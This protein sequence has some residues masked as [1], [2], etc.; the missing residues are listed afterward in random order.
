M[1]KKSAPTPIM[2]ELPTEALFHA[3]LVNGY[4]HNKADFGRLLSI[5]MGN[6]YNYLPSKGG[7]R[8][9]RPFMPSIETLRRWASMIQEHTG[10]VVRIR[11]T[12]GM[13]PV[14][15]EVSGRSANGQALSEVMVYM[16]LTEVH[17]PPSSGPDP[18][19][20]TS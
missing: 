8:R 9:T 7:T 19:E 6:V 13:G 1:S 17:E 4:I 3:L 2:V 16:T 18:A 5:C 11:L 12:D 15:F 20:L 10:L 14:G